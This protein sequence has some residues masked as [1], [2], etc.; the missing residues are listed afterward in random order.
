[1]WP[2]PGDSAANGTYG[3]PE[4]VYTIFFRGVDL[5]GPA[6]D[7]TVSADLAESDLEMP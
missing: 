1:V 7:H 6:A 2:N 5:F 3:D 4:L